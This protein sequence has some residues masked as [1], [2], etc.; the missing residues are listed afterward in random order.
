MNSQEQQTLSALKQ[1]LMQS[2][3]QH[4]IAQ[5]K[6]FLDA[7]PSEDATREAMYVMAVAYRLSGNIKNAITT[8]SQLVGLFPDY[9]MSL[10][11]I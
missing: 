8:L 7:K 6:Q 4:V 1:S 5:S 3:H 2:N 10:I 9:G 11:H